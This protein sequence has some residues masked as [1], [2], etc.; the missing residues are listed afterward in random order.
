[1]RII[2]TIFSFRNR[3]LFMK[4]KPLPHKGFLYAFMCGNGFNFS[5]R[6]AC[7]NFLKF[8]N[9]PNT[10]L[11]L[12]RGHSELGLEAAAEVVWS[13]EAHGVGYLGDVLFALTYHLGG[14]L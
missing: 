12:R 3:G 13:V 1:M 6:K 10:S 14:T 4:L 5:A 11:I 2:N 8:I 9:F 7:D